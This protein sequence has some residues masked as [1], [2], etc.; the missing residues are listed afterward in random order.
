M[1]LLFTSTID[2]CKRNILIRMTD[3]ISSRCD[4]LKDTILRERIVTFI[5]PAY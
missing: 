5:V 4:I 3:S 1:N 2:Y